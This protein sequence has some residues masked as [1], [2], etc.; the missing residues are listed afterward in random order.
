MGMYTEIRVSC[1]VR[2]DGD[3]LEALKLMFAW[4]DAAAM[5]RWYEQ[6]GGCDVAA[7]LASHPLFRCERWL[8]IGHGMSA[9]FDTD[10]KS[11]MVQLE[12]GTWRIES[13]SNLKNY[14][15]EIEKF[16][17]WLRPMVVGEPGQVIG[18]SQYE[19]AD[20]PTEVRL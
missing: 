7:R 15:D 12:N 10:P 14:D 9:Y 20:E 13:V 5:D 19:E 1:T 11:S 6:H 3:A 17:D 18:S 16:F 2:A 8:A 4:D